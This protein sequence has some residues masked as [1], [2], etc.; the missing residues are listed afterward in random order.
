MVFYSDLEK[1]SQFS[2]NINWLEKNWKAGL[3]EVVYNTRILIFCYTKY[4]VP[5]FNVGDAHESE[6]S[7][8]NLD[9]R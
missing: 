6:L 8:L 7:D 4:K 2:R 1:E 9:K 5:I 3:L